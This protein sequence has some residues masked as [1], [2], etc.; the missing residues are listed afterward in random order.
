MRAFVDDTSIWPGKTVDVHLLWEGVAPWPDDVDVFVHLRR[1]DAN[2]AQ[3]DGR[4]RYFVPDLTATSAT[5]PALHDWRQ[6]TVPDAPL[7]PGAYRVVV[8]LYNPQTGA[9]GSAG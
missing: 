3:N 7:P 4:P 2:L 6:L 8:G 1:D 9:P 5:A